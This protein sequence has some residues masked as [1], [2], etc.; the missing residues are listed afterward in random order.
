MCLSFSKLLYHYSKIRAHLEKDH[1]L[2]TLVFFEREAAFVTSCLLTCNQVFMEGK[3]KKKK[4]KKKTTK[5]TVMTELPPQI[6]YPF[7]LRCDLCSIM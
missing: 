7:I 5:Q 3:Q 6:E 2:D 1:P 4:T